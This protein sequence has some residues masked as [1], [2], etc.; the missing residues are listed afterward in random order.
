LNQTCQF[1]HHT[2]LDFFLIYAIPFDKNHE[3]YAHYLIN[4]TDSCLPLSRLIYR[5]WVK[6]AK[7]HTGFFQVNIFSFSLILRNLAEGYR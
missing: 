7:S 6:W 5:L 2:Q 4:R 1:L 3:D